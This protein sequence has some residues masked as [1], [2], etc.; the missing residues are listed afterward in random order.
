MLRPRSLIS[1]AARLMQC[2]SGVRGMSAGQRFV[3]RKHI[4]PP[5]LTEETDGPR[6]A[7]HERRP[8][9]PPLADAPA[10]REASNAQIVPAPP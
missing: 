1:R 8:G 7:C 9:P 5:P 10:G 4:C 3:K 6:R 2:R